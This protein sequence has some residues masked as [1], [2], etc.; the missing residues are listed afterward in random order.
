M[1]DFTQDSFARRHIGPDDEQVREMLEAIGLTGLDQLTDQ[2]LPEGIR[3][4]RPLGLPDPLSE[5]QYLRQLEQT[6]SRNR[7]YRSFIGTGFY[8]TVTPKVILR[9]VLENPGWYTAYTPYQAEISQGRLEALLNFQTMISSLTGM[10]IVNASLLDESTAA[11]EAMLMLWHLQRRG[12]RSKS[13]R[14]YASDRCH[15]QTLALLAGRAEPLGIE[16]VTGSP[17]DLDPQDPE[18]FGILF[19]Y[20]ATDGSLQDPAGLIGRA[21]DADL[22]V[23]VATDLL[24][25]TLLRPPGEMGADVVVG[26]SQRFGVPMGFGGPHAA[27]L[28]TRQEFQRQIPGRIIGVTRDQE[29]LPACRM[30]LQTREQHIR[31]ERATSNICTAQVLPAVMAGFYAVWHGPEGLR[32]IA[33]RVHG[34]ARLADKGVR[35]LGFLPEHPT[36]FDTLSIPVEAVLVDR[37]RE[38]ALK[39]E[40][41]LRYEEERVLLSFD[42]AKGMEDVTL[43]LDLFAAASGRENRFR[44]EKESS[45]VKPGLPSSLMRTTPFMEHPVFHSH[46]S[47]HEMLR[48]LKRLENRDL[49][50]THSMIPLGS[51][52]MKL[53]PTTAMIPITW[54]TAASLHPFAPADQTEGYRIMIGELEEWL[55]RITGFKA[56]SL[57]PN[58]GAQGEFTGLMIIRARHRDRGEAHRNVC[59]IPSSAHGTNPASAVLAGLE[60]VVTRCDE[61]GNIDP[62]DLRLQ[63]ERYSDRLA[64]LMVTYPSTHGVFEEQIREICG[65]IHQHG[66]LVYMDGANMNAQMGLTSPARIGA[67]VCH[68]NLHKTFCIP[69]GGGGPGM[70][71]VAVTEELSPYLPSHPLVRTG[72]E[73]GIAP[74][75]AAPWGSASILPIPHAFIRMMGDE[76]VKRAAQIAILNANYLMERLRGHYSILYTSRSGRAA[77]EFILDLREFRKSTGIEAVDVAKRLMDYGF[78]APTLSFPVAGT[79]MI[80]PTESESRAELDRFCEALISIRQEIREIENGEADR[81]KN[82]LKMAPHTQRVLLADVWD[83]P[84]SRERAAFPLPE[85]RHDKFWPTTSRLDEA[86][87]DKNL[88]CVCPP[89][90]AWQQQES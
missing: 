59:I 80:E 68:L 14:F 60:V 66:G 61:N 21:H 2:T 69:H 16:L 7:I 53:N 51:C 70:G 38:E 3:L 24:G 87:G 36:Y 72:G 10:E 76:G 78:H 18:L 31:R 89:P 64:A 71:P 26:S 1:I 90:E 55:A 83:R 86:Y 8:D 12:S 40:V 54:A 33:L 20:P 47:E 4:D 44:P 77:H 62:E 42:E 5:E 56:V 37:I 79:L 11:A 52:T 28:A 15:P 34:L 17:E 32:R 50:L 82:L 23:A 75:S 81:E 35:Q 19:Q 58:S 25:L 48:Y 22:L 30:A 46:R 27:W 73:K 41:N 49:S 57:Q 9:N 6:L 63:V 84:Y 39:R 13:S 29:G 65:L 88:F 67:D 85:L 45:G 43:I 74:V